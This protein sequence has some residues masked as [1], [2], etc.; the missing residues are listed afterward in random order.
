MLAAGL[1]GAAAR[2]RA[3]PVEAALALEPCVASIGDSVGVALTVT[4]TGTDAFSLVNPWLDMTS[5]AG[6]VTITAVPYQSA[7]LYLPPG[8]SAAF[9]WTLTVSGT[10]TVML[11]G[12]AVGYINSQP[13]TAASSAILV[14]PVP[15]QPAIRVLNN[16]LR[17]GRT[18]TIVLR[19]TASGAVTLVVYDE[20]GAPLG[21]AAAGT[22]ALDKNGY[23]SVRFD[24]AVRGRR[25]PTGV[26]WIAASG[27]VS[28]KA[29]VLVTSQ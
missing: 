26:Y 27:A 2:G 4:N 12:R 3:V 21:P 10:G 7:S 20:S 8:A 28:A 1:A 5:G 16:V 13:Y 29:P 15:S 6:L 18:A 23:G 25:L 17:P 14:I 9:T 24:G 22:V 19:G 11:T